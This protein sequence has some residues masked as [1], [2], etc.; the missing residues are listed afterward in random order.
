MV[1]VSG[2][3]FT[4]D[5]QHLLVSEQQTQLG[6]SI[7]Y[8]MKLSLITSRNLECLC[9]DKLLSGD[10]MGLWHRDLL[11]E[12]RLHPLPHLDW[13]VCNSAPPRCQLYQPIL[14]LWPVRSHPLVVSPIHLTAPLYRE[15]SASPS[16]P[17][18]SWRASVCSPQHSSWVSYS[19]FSGFIASLHQ[20]LSANDFTRYKA[21]WLLT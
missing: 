3:V 21:V 14:W 5:Y 15:H 12:K 11:K 1:I 13:L 19:T 2:A 4:A 8:I 7:I 16:T 20:C 6:P 18:A 9:S 17:C 10:V